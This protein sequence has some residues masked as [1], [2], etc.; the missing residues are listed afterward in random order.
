[1]AEMVFAL[2]NI[3]PLAAE[4]AAYELMFAVVNTVLLATVRV[5]KFVCEVVAEF[6]VML[7][8]QVPD[9]PVP[10]RDGE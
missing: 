5:E 4:T 2:S 6:P 3:A 9:A 10:V 8:P 7:I 1:M